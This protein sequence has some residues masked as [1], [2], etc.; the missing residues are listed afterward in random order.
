LNRTEKINMELCVRL[1]LMQALI[2]LLG[3]FK[4][5]TTLQPVHSDR[6][7]WYPVWTQLIQL[8]VTLRFQLLLIFRPC[9]SPVSLAMY[10][11]YLQQI[12]V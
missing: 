12:G 5:L 3:F 10:M 11:G 8:R 1:Q 4:P 6:L 2:I 9:F 7:I